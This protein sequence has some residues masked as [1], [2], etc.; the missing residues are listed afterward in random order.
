MGRITFERAFPQAEA[1][2][3]LRRRPDLLQ[4]LLTSEGSWVNCGGERI[5]GVDPVRGLLH[6]RAEG[7]QE[8][9]PY[10]HLLEGVPPPRAARPSRQD[11]H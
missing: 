6:P 8:R 5:T 1:L 3:L 4:E 2:H 9:G 11:R 7:R 10:A